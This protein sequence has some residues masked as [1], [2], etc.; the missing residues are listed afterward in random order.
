[1]EAVVNIFTGKGGT[2]RMIVAGLIVL[3]FADLVIENNYQFSGSRGNDSVS[4]KPS[5][6]PESNKAAQGSGDEIKDVPQNIT[7]HETL[8]SSEQ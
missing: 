2:I 3:G 4:L 5:N 8:I 6:Y 7:K 1:M